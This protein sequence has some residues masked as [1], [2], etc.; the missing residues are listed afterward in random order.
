M[1]VNKYS[2]SY[3]CAT[4]NVKK[5]EVALIRTKIKKKMT[6]LEKLKVGRHSKFQQTNFELLDQLLKYKPNYYSQIPLEF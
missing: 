6:N 3:I 1:I 4:M 5:T 2:V